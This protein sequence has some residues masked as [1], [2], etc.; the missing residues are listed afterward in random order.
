VLWHTEA[1]HPQSNGNNPMSFLSP[2]SGSEM[3]FPS[4]EDTHRAYSIDHIQALLTQAASIA[5]QE[6]M[7]LLSSLIGTVGQILGKCQG[8]CQA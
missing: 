4:A 8:N 3:P 5:E 6:D 1:A 2:V 7:M